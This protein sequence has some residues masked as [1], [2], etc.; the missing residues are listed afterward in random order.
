[1]DRIAT[2]RAGAVQ[3]AIQKCHAR[4]LGTTPRPTKCASVKRKLADVKTICQ[5]DAS[6]AAGI[7]VAHDF[8]CAVVRCVVPAGD[9]GNQRWAGDQSVSITLL[10]GKRVK[11]RL[12]LPW[13]LDAKRLQRDENE[14]RK[15][16]T[17]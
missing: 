10:A 4:G 11:A 6:K 13:Q 16:P 15:P 9:R 1:M 7:N 12:A 5:Q 8:G 3:V 2:K 17:R 14:A